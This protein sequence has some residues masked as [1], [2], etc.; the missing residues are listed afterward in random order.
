MRKAIF[1]FENI[2]ARVRPI[3]IP[4]CLRVIDPADL[5]TAMAYALIAG[6]EREAAATYIMDCI[7]QRMAA[8]MKE[9][10]AERDTV[11]PVDG[12]AAMNAVSSAIRALADEGTIT[13]IDPDAE[14][15]A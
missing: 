12:E 1:T 2:P 5:A 8:A 13:L 11:K 9:Q 7:S 6:G 4:N 10:A 3:N 15:D 14:E